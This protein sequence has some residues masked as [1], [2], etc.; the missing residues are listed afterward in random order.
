VQIAFTAFI[1]VSE[2]VFAFSVYWY[3]GKKKNARKGVYLVFLTSA[4][5]IASGKSRIESIKITV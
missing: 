2:R 5:R 4:D 3:I 1:C